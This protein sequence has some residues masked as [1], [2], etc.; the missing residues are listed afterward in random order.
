M[1]TMTLAITAGLLYWLGH[2]KVGYWFYDVF[3]QPLFMGMVFGLVAGDLKQGLLL[4]G[5]IQLVYLGMIYAGGN[6][7]ADATLAAAIAIPIALQTGIS[8]EQACVLALPFGVAGVFID[9]IRR[10]MNAV[11]I[12]KADKYAEEGN[13]AGVFKC[14]IV[15]PLI[16]GFVLRFPIVFA[17]IL[18]GGG[19][20]EQIMGY[21]PAWIMNGLSVAGG[22]LPAMG[23]AIVVHTIGEKK[24]LPYFII[25]YFAVVYMGLNTMATAIFGLCIALLVVASQKKESE[26]K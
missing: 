25:G 23:F 3:G 14:G 12:H 6:I 10:T 22:M 24:Y 5:T 18:L 26:A 11:F 19:V 1:N 21:I 9:Q 7:P 17:A 13:D 8:A 16:Q 2:C 4:G 15:Y 20:V